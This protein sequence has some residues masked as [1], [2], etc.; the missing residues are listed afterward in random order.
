MNL[1]EHGSNCTPN[2]TTFF[3]AYCHISVSL[4]MENSGNKHLEK[5]LEMTTFTASLTQPYGGL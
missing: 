3:Q 4:E 2:L 1:K 5:H